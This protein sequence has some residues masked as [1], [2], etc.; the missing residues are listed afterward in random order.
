MLLKWCV[1][2]YQIN[3]NWLLRMC[4]SNHLYLNHPQLAF[5]LGIAYMN[6]KM[7]C[8]SAKV[9]IGCLTCET[10]KLMTRAC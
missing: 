9:R 10:A 7:Q 1:P 2:L 6:G 3:Y 5:L 8:V 4:N